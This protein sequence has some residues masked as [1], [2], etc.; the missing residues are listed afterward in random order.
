[1]QPGAQRSTETQLSRRGTFSPL[2]VRSVG[3]FGARAPTQVRTVVT[4]RDT[5]AQPSPAAAPTALKTPSISLL[6]PQSVRS[7]PQ[8]CREARVWWCNNPPASYT[9]LALPLSPPQPNSLRDCT[10]RLPPGYPALILLPPSTDAPW[11]SRLD[12]LG[13][14]RNVPLGLRATVRRVPRM[15]GVSFPAANPA[16]SEGRAA[17]Q[18]GQARVP[19]VVPAYAER[20]RRVVAAGKLPKVCAG[21]LPCRPVAAEWGSPALSDGGEMPSA[22]RGRRRRW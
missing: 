2:G 16:A 10:R 19:S 22:A 21:P 4:F 13:L 15:L 11:R 3:Q 7:M 8:M 14:R 18:A 9:L 1:M 20:P 6:L 17:R 5:R 12:V